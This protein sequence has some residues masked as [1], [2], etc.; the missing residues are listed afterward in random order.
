MLGLRKA[1]KKTLLIVVAVLV[2]MSGMDP[3]FE[4]VC[5]R[6]SPA[7][8]KGIISQNTTWTLG[9]SPYVITSSV[10]VANGTT[11]TIE[12]NVEVRFD[13]N[14]SLVIN[15]SLYAVGTNDGWISFTS[16][17][18][19]P[20]PGGWHTIKFAGA[21]NEFLCMENCIVEYAKTGITIQSMGKASIRNSSITN[22]SVSGIHVIDESNLIVKGNTIRLNEDGISSIGDA[23]SGIRVLNNLF[24]RNRNGIHLYA[25]SSGISRISNVTIQGN[26]FSHNE[27]GIKFNM[28]PITWGKIHNVNISQNAVCFNRNGVYFDIWGGFIDYATNLIYDTLISQ[29]NVYSN[30]R[31]GI[32]V[33]CSGPWLGTI[34]RVSISNNK[35]MSNGV[36]VHLFANTH[37][38]YIDFD[39][40]MSNNTVR[41][42]IDK[43]IYVF[44]GAFREPEEG[45]RTNI[46]GNSIS[47][48][49]YGAFYEGDTD[50]IAH[51]NDVYNNTCGAC[52]SNGATLNATHNY[53][54]D[55][56]GPHHEVLN[57]EGKGN[58]VKGDE[59]DLVLQPFLPSAV[60]NRP[61]IAVLEINETV[62][63]TNQ[64][65]MF[66]ASE[67]SDDTCITGYFFDFGD[68]AD[69][70]W[71]TQPVA[72]HAY[73]SLGVYNASLRVLDDLGF[74]S[75]NT[76]FV[77]VKV[78]PTLVVFVA[79]DSEAVHSGEDLTITVRVTEGLDPISGANVTL[80]SDTDGV[81]SPKAGQT[82]S[83][84]YLVSVLTAPTVTET[85]VITITAK[86]TETDYHDGQGQIEVNVLP[87]DVPM[88]IAFIWVI[89][90]IA[91]TIIAIVSV[92]K[93][94]KMR[95]PHR[96]TST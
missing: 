60:A 10:T 31:Y 94:R 90:A 12:P 37:Y 56:T 73:A 34:Y 15:G 35:I 69:S 13:G 30:E 52:V 82:D 87:K 91:V 20:R 17:D 42:N 39:V 89:A 32:Y 45:I 18:L 43:G 19:T 64:M 51:F 67:S 62:T 74:E 25:S 84:G 50:N 95:R 88:E 86:A 81:F 58:P 93:I 96:V 9:Q 70:G 46:T 49:A 2:F 21:D 33:N 66:D 6:E 7:F 41:G 85:T 72:E 11:L 59:R 47:Y 1:H 80:F 75:G 29:N 77:T 27:N 23:T 83:A 14:F 92:S 3:V 40:V 22:S 54:G 8:V 36:G 61:P 4:A 24:D 55:P 79:A 65:I 5:L 76:A 53:W 71:I 48:N 44:G 63:T 16:N 28:F 68:G 57:T 38:R 78:Q 26:N